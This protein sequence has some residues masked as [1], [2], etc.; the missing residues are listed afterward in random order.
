MR[1]YLPQDRRGGYHDF[2]HVYSMDTKKCLTCGQRKPSSKRKSPIVLAMTLYKGWRVV[3][4]PLTYQVQRLMPCHHSPGGNPVWTKVQKIPR[5][6][7]EWVDQEFDSAM[8]MFE[9]CFIKHASVGDIGLR[10]DPHYEVERLDSHHSIMHVRQALSFRSQLRYC[11]L[12]LR[13]DWMT[14]MYWRHHYYH[15]RWRMWYGR[16]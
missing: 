12:V 7:N 11:Y 10:N 6:R 5:T 4:T 13:P 2:R 8:A 3:A 1:T 9:R 16:E 14:L 15:V